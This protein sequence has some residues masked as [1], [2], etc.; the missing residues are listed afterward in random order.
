MRRKPIIWTSLL[1]LA[2]FVVRAIWREHYYHL[3]ASGALGCGSANVKVISRFGTKE[4]RSGLDTYRLLGPTI[5]AE[6]LVGR[7]KKRIAKIKPDADPLPYRG[8]SRSEY[9]LMLSVELL[10]QI[11]HPEATSLLLAL[12]DDP[13]F[14]HNSEEW[15]IEHNDTSVCPALLERW[16]AK[17]K[18]PYFYVAIFNHMPYKPATPML[19]NLFHPYIGDSDKEY[20]FSTIE[21]CAGRSVGR[22]RHARLLTPESCSELKR[23]LVDWW[24]KSNEKDPSQA[25]QT[26]PRCGAG[27]ACAQPAPDLAD[28]SFLHTT[29][30]W[31]S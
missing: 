26:T 7:V 1:V 30:P 25:M 9:E 2:V 29:L 5:E 3:T 18:Y 27:F 10:I 22:L 11:K 4:V 23:A 31:K 20:L 12:V 13:V 6:E 8:R 16:K 15:L 14:F 24:E 17:P 21:K 28:S 19:F